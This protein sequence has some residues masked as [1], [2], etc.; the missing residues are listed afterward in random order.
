MYIPLIFVN[1]EEE[2]EE[3]VFQG[4]EGYQSMMK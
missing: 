1:G 3:T 4:G 2:I